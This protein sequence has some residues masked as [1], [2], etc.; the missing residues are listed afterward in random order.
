[1]P[2]MYHKSYNYLNF[3]SLESRL[4]K[5]LPTFRSAVI[6]G[7]MTTTDAVRERILRAAVAVLD[8]GCETAVRVVGVCEAARV[9]Q[10]MVR[11]HFGVLIGAKSAS[12]GTQRRHRRSFS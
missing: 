7:G 5:Q 1:M 4:I 12:P 2:K 11:Y 3:C 9:T 10:G 6:R 8:E